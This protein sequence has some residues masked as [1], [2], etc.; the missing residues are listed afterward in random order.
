M[1]DQA[2]RVVLVI[3]AVVASSWACA[4]EQPVATVPWAHLGQG[5][6]RTCRSP[7]AGPLNA[8]HVSK[9]LLQFTDEAL[10]HLLLD[11]DGVLQAVSL[12]GCLYKFNAKRREDELVILVPLPWSPTDIALGFDGT[13]YITMTEG[14]YG[15]LAAI[16][17]DVILWERQFPARDEIHVLPTPDFMILV[18]TSDGRMFCLNTDGEE[19][20]AYVVPGVFERCTR[21]SIGRSGIIYFSANGVRSR[22]SAFIEDSCVFAVS[23][24]GVE[25]WER[26]APVS[27]LSYPVIDEEENVYMIGS[28]G[29]LYSFCSAGLNWAEPATDPSQEAYLAYFEGKIIVLPGG[30]VTAHCRSGQRQPLWSVSLGDCFIS[31]NCMRKS[32][33]K[34]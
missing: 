20:W 30:N 5:P 28:D 19:E 22:T 31:A 17:D 24:D 16:K 8:P 11:R 29:L 25:L 3:V 21:P 13:V 32:R 26:P 34:P 23:R 7:Y 18:L 2:L 6:D 9:H 15:R 14:G 33:L 12:D 1:F 4:Q 27:S 10:T